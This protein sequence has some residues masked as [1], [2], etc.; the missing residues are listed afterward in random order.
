MIDDTITAI[1]ILVASFAGIYYFIRW[2]RRYEA[3]LREELFQ[4]ELGHAQD[5]E[6]RK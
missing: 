3:K 5:R 6:D 4:H 1:A 2:D